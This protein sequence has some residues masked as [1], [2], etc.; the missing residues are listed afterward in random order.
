MSMSE[1]RCKY[2]GNIVRV[3]KRRFP[4]ADLDTLARLY[5]RTRQGQEWVHISS[6][7][8]HTSGCGFAKFR[9]WDFVQTRHT[10]ADTKDS[11]FWRLTPIG[12][13]F[14][15]GTTKAWTHVLL[16]NAHFI[17]FSGDEVSVTEAYRMA[18]FSFAELMKPFPTPSFRLEG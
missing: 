8:R 9:Y 10:E 3:Y 4:K 1:K 18:G 7:K 17:G 12:E 13:S 16:R 5:G 6:I 2:C 11:G 15:S 14:M